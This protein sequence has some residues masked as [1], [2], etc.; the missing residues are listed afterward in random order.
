M[1]QTRSFRQRKR[2]LLSPDDYKRQRRERRM[3][4]TGALEP[5]VRSWAEQRGCALHVVRA[6]VR[7]R[8]ELLANT[9]LEKRLADFQP[10]VP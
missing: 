2:I 3:D 6:F 4:R 1:K 10:P 9:T 7:L 5:L 8:N